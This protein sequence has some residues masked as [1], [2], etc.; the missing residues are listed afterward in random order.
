MAQL[1]VTLHLYKPIP[2]I[3]KA[4]YTLLQ[5]KPK[6]NNNNKKHAKNS[7]AESWISSADLAFSVPDTNH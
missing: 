4:T 5:K 6:H 2:G 3:K 7:S 1:V